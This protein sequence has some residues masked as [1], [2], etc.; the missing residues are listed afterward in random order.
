MKLL[1]DIKKIDHLLR[2]LGKLKSKM[3]MG[4]TVQAWRDIHSLEAWIEKE[5]AELIKSSQPKEEKNDGE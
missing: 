4:Q 3:Y 2:E 5:K 1:E